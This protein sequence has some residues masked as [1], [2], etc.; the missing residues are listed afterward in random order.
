MNSAVDVTA[1]DEARVVLTNLEE[2]ERYKITIKA[3]TK[4]GQYGPASKQKIGI[5]VNRS[6]FTSLYIK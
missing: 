4:N 2:G 3:V 5:P 6:T 1:Y